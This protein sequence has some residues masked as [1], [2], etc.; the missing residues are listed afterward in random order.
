MHSNREKRCFSFDFIRTAKAT[1][2]QNPSGADALIHEY[3]DDRACEHGQGVADAIDG[4]QRCRRRLWEALLK[5][6]EQDAE[7]AR[8]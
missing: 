1:N 3:G 5:D 8:Q 2:Y 4:R 7:D 6:D